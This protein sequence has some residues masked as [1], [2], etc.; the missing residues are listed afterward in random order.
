MCWMV[1]RT[2]N[3]Q[4]QASIV[5]LSGGCAI[6]KTINFEGFMVEDAKMTFQTLFR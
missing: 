4:N 5:L 6:K 1:E 2:D 3:R